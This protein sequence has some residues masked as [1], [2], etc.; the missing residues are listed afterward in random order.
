MTTDILSPARHVIGTR[1]VES[2]KAY[3]LELTG[4]HLAAG[5]GDVTTMDI[6]QDRII[7]DADE[8]GIIT[9]LRI[10]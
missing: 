3:L 7:I 4:L 10:S 2:V 8:A 1:Y 9:Q 6:R 5:P